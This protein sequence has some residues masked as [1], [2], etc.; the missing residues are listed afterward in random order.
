MCG[1]IEQ[2]VPL[3]DLK[4]LYVAAQAVFQLWDAMET[5]ADLAFVFIHH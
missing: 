2:R 3:M 5:T 1:G 4:C